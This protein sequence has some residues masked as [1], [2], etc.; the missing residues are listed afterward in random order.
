MVEILARILNMNPN[1]G[2]KEL[3][4]TVTPAL[5]SRTLSQKLMQELSPNKAGENWVD[6]LCS[7]HDRANPKNWWIGRF[8]N[9]N[10]LSIRCITSVQ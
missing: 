1:V 6:A 5:M 10:G 3:G 4:M 7:L 9:L 8:L 2:P